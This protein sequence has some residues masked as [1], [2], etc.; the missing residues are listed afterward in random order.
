MINFAFMGRFPIRLFYLAIN[1]PRRTQPF[2][3]RFIQKHQLGR[4][5]SESVKLQNSYPHSHTLNERDI[6]GWS[7]YKQTNNQLSQ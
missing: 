1:Y 4:M 6:D 2:L 5:A 7:S 3:F